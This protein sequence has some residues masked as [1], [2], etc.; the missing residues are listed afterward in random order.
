MDGRPVRRRR[1][2]ASANRERILEVA[3]PLLRERGEALR[4]EDVSAAAGVGKG[5]LYRNYANRAAL[6][7]AVLDDI[8]RDLQRRVLAEVSVPGAPPLDRLDR[9]VGMAAAFVVEN[10]G[11]LCIAREGRRDDPRRSAPYLWQRM[12]V[13]GLLDEAARDAG[14]DPAVVAYAPD[15]VLGLIDP[16]LVRYGLETL[17]LRPDDVVRAARTAAR[18][19]AAPG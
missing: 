10:L 11:L 4:M 1:R 8:A 17:G 14:R 15:A 16:A 12:V 7:E 2:D 19:I 5:T 9:F 3:G 6:A 13:A 18:G